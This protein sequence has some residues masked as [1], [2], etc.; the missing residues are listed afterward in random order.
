MFEALCPQMY[1][2]FSN[3]IHF[4]YKH[5][6]GLHKICH[7]RMFV[8]CVAFCLLLFYIEWLNGNFLSL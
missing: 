7:G 5:C 1:K 4:F 2:Y 6:G 3:V 8:I